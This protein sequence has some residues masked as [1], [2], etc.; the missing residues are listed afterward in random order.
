MATYNLA[1]LHSVL[2]FAGARVPS[3]NLSTLNPGL[4]LAGGRMP[5]YGRPLSTRVNIQEDARTTL[6]EQPPPA[7]VMT[8][9]LGVPIMLPCKLEDKML[10]NEPLITLSGTKRVVMTEVDGQDGTFKELYSIGDM[11]VVIQ[12]VC[13]NDDDPDNYPRDQVQMIRNLVE[14][15]RHLSITNKLTELWNITH[16]SVLSY[17]F[18][19]IPGE[20]GVQGYELRCVSD[21]DFKLRLRKR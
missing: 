15:P 1:D 6:S 4:L 17:S 19:A 3:Q 7:D 5:T 10:P 18:P 2:F 14:Q 11:E 16:V 13:V 12:G 9:L 20:I 21:R 8:G